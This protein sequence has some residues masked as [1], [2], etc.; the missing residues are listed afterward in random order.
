MSS[1]CFQWLVYQ[2]FYSFK[3]TVTNIM[4]VFSYIFSILKKSAYIEMLLSNGILLDMGFRTWNSQ[5]HKDL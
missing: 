5:Q 3:G 1:K 2:Y 4:H